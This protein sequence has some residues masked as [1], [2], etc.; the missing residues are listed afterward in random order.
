MLSPIVNTQ[1]E[2]LASPVY[3]QAKLGQDTKD[4]GHHFSLMTE[5]VTAGMGVVV[6]QVQMSALPPGTL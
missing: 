6:V 3:A 1:T 2:F 5:A 4:I